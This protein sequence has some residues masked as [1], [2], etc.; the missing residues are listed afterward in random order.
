[1]E[2]PRTKLDSLYVL[3]HKAIQEMELLTRLLNQIEDEIQECETR[4]MLDAK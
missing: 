4:I 2:D 3:L 1:M